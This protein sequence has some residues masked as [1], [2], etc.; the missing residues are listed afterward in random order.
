MLILVTGG[1]GFIGC[2]VVL[3]LVQAGHTVEVL[4]NLSNSLRTSLHDVHSIC[5]TLPLLHECP[6][7][8]VARVLQGRSFDALVH[9]ASLKSV[10]DSV[11]NPLDYYEQNLAGTI[12][13]CRA[14]VQHR[15]PR[16]IFSS[17][18]CV[19]GDHPR[20]DEST[21]TA[22]RNPYGHSKLFSERIIQDT[23][24]AHGLA[25]V[26]LRYFNPAGAHQSGALGELPLHSPKNLMPLLCSAALGEST[27]KVFGSRLPTADGSPVRDYIHVE[28]LASGHLAALSWLST[29]PPGEFR[30]VNL[31]SGQG[32]SV[33]QIASEMACV[34]EREVRIECCPPR[35]GDSPCYVADP[36]LAAS[37][38][39]WSARLSLRSICRDAWSAYLRQKSDAPPPS[40]GH[41]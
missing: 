10:E 34:C 12:A 30:S 36:S 37:L 41:K 14:A 18:A 20:P 2:N 7:A 33:F 38:F 31:G 32:V 26:C 11:I 6:V 1:A 27:L 40:P 19:Y 4:D 5:G 13:V 17:S 29:R 8:D 39:G 23:C 22:P 35:P 25:A 16:L 21:S 28:D 3:A 15:V 9:L 24:L